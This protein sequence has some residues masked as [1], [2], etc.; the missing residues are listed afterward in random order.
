M[1]NRGKSSLLSTITAVICIVLYAAALIYGAGQ[2]I[3]SSQDRNLLADNEFRDIADRASSA[4]VTGFM[5]TPYQNAI[6][7]SILNSQTILGVI[8]TGSNDEYGFERQP[9]TVINYIGNS[10]RFKTGFGISGT[11]HYQ[12]IWIEG[13]RNT[14]VQAIHSYLDY[15]LFVQVLKQTLLIIF[16]VMALAVFILLLDINLK[17]LANKAKP[18]KDYVPKKTPAA[19]S[20]ESRPVYPDFGEDE[21]PEPDLPEDDFTE[22]EFETESGPGLPED[23]F[24]EPEFETEPAPVVTAVSDPH[25]QTDI[26]K[27]EGYPKGLYSPRGIGWESY[28]SERLESELHRCASSEEDL[29]FM[30]MEPRNNDPGDEFF[31]KLIA[32]CTGF[33]TLRDMIFEKGK[34]ALSLII[35]DLNVDHGFSKSEEFRNMVTGRITDNSGNPPDLCIGLS[36]RAGRLVEAERLM[37]EASQAAAKALADPQSSVVAFKSDPEKYRNF[38]SGKAS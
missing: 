29:V 34:K 5:S 32:E 18:E 30:V 23:D 11:P 25:N 12:S 38:I 1:V 4:A 37:L 16:A 24:T 8:I 2:I 28:T 14:T 13:Q 20:A 22:P 17:S 36:S 3:V 33:F 31:K 10:P 27:T 6:M 9:G 15:D 7:E 26:P 19:P 35:P 21:P